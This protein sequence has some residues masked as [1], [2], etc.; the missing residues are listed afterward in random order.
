M[1][2]L[3]RRKLLAKSEVFKQQRATSP[4][5]AKNCTYEE[6]DGVDHPSVLSHFACGRQPSILLKSRPDRVLAND[7]TSRFVAEN[8]ADILGVPLA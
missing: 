8:I 2:S 4:E 3:Q 1:L 5:Q 6:Q 7:S